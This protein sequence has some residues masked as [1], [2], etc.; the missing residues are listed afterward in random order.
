MTADLVM[1]VNARTADAWL[2]SAV[3]LRVH[4]F[5]LHLVFP[6]V[7]SHSRVTGVCPV[8]TVVADFM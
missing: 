7:S 8:T 5:G 3:T 4:R 2:A 6:E 1:R